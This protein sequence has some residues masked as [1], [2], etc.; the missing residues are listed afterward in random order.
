MIGGLLWTTFRQK[1]EGATMRNPLIFGE[2]CRNR[3]DNLMIK[4]YQG[5]TIPFINQSFIR[6][7]SSPLSFWVTVF[8]HVRIQSEWYEIK[9]DFIFDD[10]N[11]KREFETDLKELFYIVCDPVF[12]RTFEEME[13]AQKDFDNYS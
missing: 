8:L 7:K 10:E 5:L 4:S 9:G 11:H 3:T 2:P 1:R 12:I 13:A 6:R